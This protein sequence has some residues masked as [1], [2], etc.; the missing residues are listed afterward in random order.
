MTRFVGILR[1]RERSLNLHKTTH[2]KCAKYFRADSCEEAPTNRMGSGE[3]RANMAVGELA[4]DVVSKAIREVARKCVFETL[5]TL[6]RRVECRHS[7]T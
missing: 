2:H 3:A 4:S 7:V 6:F 1:E 5:V